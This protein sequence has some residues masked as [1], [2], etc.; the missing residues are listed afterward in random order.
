[1]KKYSI[2]IGVIIITLFSYCEKEITIDLPEPEEKIVVEGWIEQDDYPVVIVTK[3]AP[4]FAAVDSASLFGLI[5]TDAKVTVSDGI[6]Y[7]ELSLSINPD[8]FPYLVYNGNFIKGEIGKT[9]YLTVE[10]E[11]K[12]LTASTTI[13]QLVPF[14]SVWFKLEPQKDTLGFLW[15]HLSDDPDADNFYR[16]FTKRINEDKKFIPIFGS[17]YEDKFFN[18]QS[19][20]FSIYRGIESFS[21][22]S[23]YENYHEM[24]YFK[25]GDTIVVK[26][27]SIDEAHYKFW[28]TL[29]QEMYSG[30]SPFAVP[31][32]IISNIQGGGLGVWGGYAVSLDT[33]IAQ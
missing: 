7:E 20:A 16:I 23:E 14:D 13:P 2:L 22:E 33:V 8:Y 25:I 9:Y 26:N 28:R 32:T 18:G 12:T 27:C 5:V 10:V 3:N 6:N 21:D 17:A 31:T 4:Y 15:A 1:M 24:G 29:E 19:F 30:G 11:G